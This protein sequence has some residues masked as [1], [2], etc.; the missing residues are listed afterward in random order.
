MRNKP[1]PGMMKHSP[2]KQTKGPVMSKNHP[3]TPPT[4][5]QTDKSKGTLKQGGMIHHGTWN[6]PEIWKSM[7]ATHKAKWEKMLENQNPFERFKK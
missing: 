4:K 3:V 6:R 2:M 7:K 5:E 1:L